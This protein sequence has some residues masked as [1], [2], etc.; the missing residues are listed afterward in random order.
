MSGKKH[1]RRLRERRPRPSESERQAAA[2][3]LIDLLLDESD[4]GCVLVAVAAMDS[5]LDDLLRS[6]FEDRA[7]RGRESLGKARQNA[8]EWLFEG[9]LPPLG[10][11]VVKAKLAFLFGM[12]NDAEFEL[13]EVFRG[14]RN[15]FAH[16][17]DQLVLTKDHIQPLKRPAHDALSLKGQGRVLPGL[18]KLVNKKAPEKFSDERRS[19]MV[20]A[21]GLQ[22]WLWVRSVPV[23]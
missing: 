17:P 18:E 19:F 3:Q 23:Y 16:I 22:L 14:L 13:L 4:R 12:L 1:K 15:D 2:T 21:V 7:S 11:L 5:A 9:Q 20:Y 6:Y 8:I 10:N